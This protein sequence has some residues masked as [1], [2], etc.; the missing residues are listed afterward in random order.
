[1]HDEISSGPI[2]LVFWEES[3]SPWPQAVELPGYSIEYGFG[4]GAHKLPLSLR[5]IKGIFEDWRWFFD[6]TMFIQQ[7]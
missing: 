1:M 7:H 5:S 4:I 3:E 6:G 2:L